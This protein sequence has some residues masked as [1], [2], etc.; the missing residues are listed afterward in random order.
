MGWCRSV[1]LYGATELRGVVF[2][3]ECREVVVPVVWLSCFY[4]G[5]YLDN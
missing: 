5:I 3:G 4:D 2:M 1:F